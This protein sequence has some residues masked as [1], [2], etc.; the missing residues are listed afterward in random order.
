MVGIRVLFLKGEFVGGRF[1]VKMNYW[2]FLEEGVV[3][4]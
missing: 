1:V 2:V 3:E 4:I